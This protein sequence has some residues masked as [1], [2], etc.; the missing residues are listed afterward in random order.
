VF[1]EMTVLLH[2]YNRKV[3][4]TDQLPRGELGPALF[5]LFGEVGS[6]VAVPKKQRREG[7]V[8]SA[9]RAA[10]EEEFGDI[11]W[12]LAAVCRRLNIELEDIFRGVLQDGTYQST[13]AATS[14][15]SGPIAAVGIAA[16]NPELD[17]S[18]STLAQFSAGLFSPGSDKIE[19]LRQFAQ[20]FVTAMRAAKVSFADIAN[21]NIQKV[22]GRFLAPEFA[23]LPRFDTDFDEDERLPEHFEISIVQRSTGRSYLKWNGV[24]IGDPLTD[25]IADKDGYRFH[26]VFHMAHTA[27]LHWSP[28]FRALIKHKRK[29][30]G[31]F[32]EEQDSGRAIVVEEGL[33]AWVFSRVKGQK[34]HEGSKLSFDLLKTVRQFVAGYEVEQCPL[35][36]WERAILSGHVVFRQVLANSGG[37][38]IGDRSA[39]TISYRRLG[40]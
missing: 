27:I 34:L 24:F 35:S 29:S 11:L 10:A 37:I 39:R 31:N 32:D 28:V 3:E 22:C 1:G 30:K 7:E 12:Y 19:A 26:D 9:Y 18:L 36:L 20:A 33:T 4:P 14:L 25:N 6:L 2:E 13:L 16:N 23:A 38:V 8:F 5:G 15:P 40:E 17:S 21:A